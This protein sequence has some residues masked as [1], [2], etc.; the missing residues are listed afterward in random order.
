MIV[1]TGGEPLLRPDIENTGMQL[2]QRGFPWGIV[3]NGMTL[4]EKRL[5]SLLTQG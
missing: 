1:F 3:S 5:N 2:Y 4:T